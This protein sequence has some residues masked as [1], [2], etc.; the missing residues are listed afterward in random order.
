M[1]CWQNGR[2]KGT[3]IEAAA[4]AGQS[5]RVDALHKVRRGGRIHCSKCVLPV[6]RVIS[7]E[8]M[9]LTQHAPAHEG[10]LLHGRNSL[11][12]QLMVHI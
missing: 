4:R 6:V 3:Q 5:Y 11:E 9:T 8:A 12:M 2:T 7:E 10:T 1:P